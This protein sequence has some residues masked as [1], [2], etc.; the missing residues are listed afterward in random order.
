MVVVHRAHGF[1]F[2]IFVDDHEPAHVHIKGSGDAKIELVGPVGLPHLIY[3]RGITKAD[4]RRLLIE[5]T[6]QRDAFLR[7]WEHIHGTG[8]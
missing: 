5:V 6:R 7:Q 4:M 8:R 1:R 3:S 2:V